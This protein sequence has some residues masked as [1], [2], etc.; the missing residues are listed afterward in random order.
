MSGKAAAPGAGKQGK[1]RSLK[2]AGGESGAVIDELF[3]S[4]PKRAAR[5]PPVA[6]AEAPASKPKARG[7]A[8]AAGKAAADGERKPES[9]RRQQDYYLDTGEKLVPVRCVREQ[10]CVMLPLA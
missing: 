1:K 4:I 9:R 8:A 3:A 2:T 7:G 6:P 10:G 5:E